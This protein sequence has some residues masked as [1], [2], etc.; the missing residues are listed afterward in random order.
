[1]TEAR[2]PI[3]LGKTKLGKIKGDQGLFDDKSSRGA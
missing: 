2:K 1:M 3:W